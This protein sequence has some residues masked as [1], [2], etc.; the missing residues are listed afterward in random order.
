MGSTISTKRAGLAAAAA[1]LAAVALVSIPAGFPLPVAVLG[2]VA[3]AGGAVALFRG[4]RSDRAGADRDALV[5]RLSHELRT[6]LTAVIGVLEVL[7]EGGVTLDAAETTELLGLARRDAQQM[8]RLVDNLLIASRLARGTLSPGREVVVLPTAVNHA[9]AQT[10]GVARR[11]FV[12]ADPDP[13]ALADPV[14]VQQILTNLVQNAARHAPEGQVEVAVSRQRGEVMVRISDDGPGIPARERETVFAPPPGEIVGSK[15]LGL[16]LPLSRDLAR[17]MGGEL[18]CDPPVRAGST[19]TL[20]LPAAEEGHTAAQADLPLVEPFPA[21]S[22]R[23][24]LLVDMTEAL[25]ERSVDRMLAGLQKLYSGL[26]GARAGVLAVREPSGRFTR[27]GSFGAGSGAVVPAEDQWLQEAVAAQAPVVVQDLSAGIGDWPDL[28]GGNAAL[29]LPVLDRTEALGVLA[30]GWRDGS[31]LPG[32]QGVAVASALATLAAFSLQRSSLAA[33]VAFERR[34]RVSVMEALPIAI[35]VFAGDPPQVIDWNEQERRLLGLEDDSLRPVD[36]VESQKRFNVR[37]ADGTPLDL[38]NAPAT[39]AIR[40]GRSAGPFLLRVRRLDGTEVYTRT[41]C[42][43]F[44]DEQGRVAGAV[45]TS[46][47]VGTDRTARPDA[48]FPAD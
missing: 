45:V 10:P 25:A 33:D 18:T 20:R 32:E 23:A 16:G 48:D 43:P 12:H 28:L 14:L 44:F 24:R 39:Q 35:S 42:A 36:L 31:E 7:D 9:L 34:L 5:S 37:F 19:F 40:S 30:I 41:Y 11:T 47:E 46:E 17:A 22:P 1:V 4:G 15:G 27:A 21:M 2:A 3:S 26:L 8:K 13:V 38:D 6:P 29:F